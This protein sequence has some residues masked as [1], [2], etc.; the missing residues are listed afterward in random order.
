MSSSTAMAVRSR[1]ASV[2]SCR[3]KSSSWR[4]W[5]SLV[6]CLQ[7]LV[8]FLQ[9]SELVQAFFELAALEGEQIE[10]QTGLLETFVD[11]HESVA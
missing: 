4:G 11:G 1:L 8:A 5:G 2:R 9:I 6:T 3:A 10:L 7:L